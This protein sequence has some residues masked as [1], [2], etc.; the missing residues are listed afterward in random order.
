MQKLHIFHKSRKIKEKFYKQV[1]I[2]HP[3][4]IGKETVIFQHKIVTQDNGQ[5][6]PPAPTPS[7]LFY[8]F[9]PLLPPHRVSII[10]LLYG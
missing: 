5:Y 6:L 4:P 10:L 9:M 3:V 1:R 2:E 7:G 8:Y